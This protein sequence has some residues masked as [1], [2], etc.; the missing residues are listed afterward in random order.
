MNYLIRILV[1]DNG[2]KRFDPVWCLVV[3]DTGNMAFCSGEFFGVGESG[4]VYEVKG[5]KRGGIT[6]PKCLDKIKLIK[7]VKL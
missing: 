1:D 4:V 3:H 7:A 6:C 2:E 5:C